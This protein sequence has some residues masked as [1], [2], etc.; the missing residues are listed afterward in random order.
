MSS[1]ICE[2]AG[3]SA[4]F[5][6]RAEWPR[7]G[8]NTGTGGLDLPRQKVLTA[9][10]GFSGATLAVGIRFRNAR[11]G[12]PELARGIGQGEPELRHQVHRELRT[13]PR[14]GGGA[15]RNSRAL[16]CPRPPPRPPSQGTP[17]ELFHSV[18]N[19]LRGLTEVF[20]PLWSVRVISNSVYFSC[21]S[22]MWALTSTR[23]PRG[24]KI[25]KLAWC[26]GWIVGECGDVR[27]R[28]CIAW[29]SRTVRY[30]VV[31]R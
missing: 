15:R 12:G 8:R 16:I 4:A 2:T 25:R 11:H 24:S 7:N 5:V 22:G 20:W 13:P 23:K 6:W 27:S 31:S 21:A 3:G 14:A 17:S 19:A 9:R 28:A 29:P 10:D 18:N 30:R 26:R 1:R